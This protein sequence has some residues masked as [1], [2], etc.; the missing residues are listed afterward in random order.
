MI[1]S[2]QSFAETYAFTYVD[3]GARWGAT[4]PVLELF[5]NHRVIGFEPDPEE[6]ARLQDRPREKHTYFPVGVA[7]RSGRRKLYITESLGWTSILPPNNEFC[8]KFHGLGDFLKIRQE[9]EIEVRTIDELAGEDSDSGLGNADFI[10]IN[11]Q[12]ISA[13]VIEGAIT[14]FSDSILAAEIEVEFV[15]MYQGERLFS[16]VHTLM[17]EAGFL[18]FEL[19]KCRAYRE[20]YSEKMIGNGQVLWG[21]TIYLK[22]CHKMD[23]DTSGQKRSCLALIATKLGFFDYASEIAEMLLAENLITAEAK[24]EHEALVS[25]HIQSEMQKSSL[26]YRLARTET[27]GAILTWLKG[28]IDRHWPALVYSVRPD[29]YFRRD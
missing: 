4:S 14:V 7:G 3:V 12:G 8:G 2:F 28:T 21:D 29:Y 27:G 25:E 6:F 24:A 17:T 10:K 1:N 13:D 23:E 20:K 11:A 9:T 26:V 22:D 19:T 15:E 5:P 16:D 18:L